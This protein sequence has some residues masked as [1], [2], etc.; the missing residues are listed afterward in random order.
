M[1]RPFLCKGP[2]NMEL[3]FTMLLGAIEVNWVLDTDSEDAQVIRD[4]V[5]RNEKL[6]KPHE[7]YS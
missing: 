4:A 5:A 1:L 3:E 2:I 7:R 6:R